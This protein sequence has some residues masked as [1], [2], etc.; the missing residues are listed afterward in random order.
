VPSITLKGVTFGRP[1]AAPRVGVK[2]RPVPNH[3][4]RRYLGFA[5]PKVIERISGLSTHK[6]PTS[7]SQEIGQI[8]VKFAYFEQC[9]QEMVWQALRLNDATG[10]IAVREPRVTD[11]LDMLRD[12]VGIRGGYF[13]EALFKSIRQRADLIAARRNMLA[14]G[15]WFHHKALGE[16]RVQLTRGAWPKTEEELVAGSKKIIPESVVMTVDELRATIAEIDELIDALKR[17]RTD[18]Y[19]APST[20]RETSAD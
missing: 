5:M 3:S 7:F 13:D 10:R 16:W 1:S 6:L 8:I 9:V 4:S 18:A 2:G 14:H 20:P 17:L 11:R 19:E 15:I 12:V